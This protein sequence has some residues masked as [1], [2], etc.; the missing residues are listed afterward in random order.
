MKADILDLTKRNFLWMGAAVLAS[1][2]LINFWD[3]GRA[4]AAARAESDFE[5]VQ[6]KIQKAQDYQECHRIWSIH[7]WTDAAGF[8]RKQI[9]ETFAIGQPDVAFIQGNAMWVGYETIRAAY[10]D[11]DEASAQDSV[12]KMRETHPEIPFDWRYKYLGWQKAHCNATPLIYIAGDRKTAKA[13]YESPGYGMWERFY[14]DYIM[15]KGFWKIWHMNILMVMSTQDGQSWASG[16]GMF[17]GAPPGAATGDD[18]A[19]AAA[20]GA[21]TGEQGGAPAGQGGASTGGQSAAPGTYGQGEKPGDDAYG[22]L[23][24][25]TKY[26]TRSDTYQ[27]DNLSGPKTPLH[28][29]LPVPY[30][31]FSETHSYGPDMVESWARL[32]AKTKAAEK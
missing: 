11:W 20:A 2:K 9:M 5:R 29:R 26:E 7:S 12:R 17:G 8:N 3:T 6:K 14:I 25:R 31:T 19:K 28:P 22:L 24:E 1:L 21:S 15:E 13:A 30:N 32:D 10:C 4:E 16:R 18:V 27:Q 23:P